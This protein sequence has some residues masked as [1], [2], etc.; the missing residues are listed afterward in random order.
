MVQVSYPGVY[1]Q[2]IPSGFR[3]ISGVA[4]SIAAFVGMAK[5]G[6]L[7][8][9][10]RVLGLKDYERIFSADTSQG[11]MTEQVRQFFIN[12]GEQAFIV[13]IAQDAQP[14]TVTLRNADGTV[15]MTLASRDAGLDAN[16]IRARVDYN[17]SSPERTF[18]LTLF[19]ETFD[20]NGAPIVSVLETHAGLGMDPDGPRFAQ[21]V[22]S[23]QS[24]LATAEVDAAAVAAAATLEA[25]SASAALF[26]DEA[27]VVTAMTNA[28]AD[29]GGTAG[30][31]RVKVGD[32]PW[33]TVEFPS[34][35]LA[36]A[37]IAT[38]INDLLAPHTTV[39]VAASVAANGPLIIRADT[40]G[41]DVLVDRA[42]QLDIA[43]ALGLGA[44][45]GGIEVGS[46]AAAR[47]APSGLV[48]VLDGAAAG[49]LAALLA[50]GGAAKADFDTPGIGGVR[51]FTVP[52]AD[53]AYPAPAPGDMNEGTTDGRSL[54]NIRENLEAIAIAM[55][56]ASDDWRAEVHGHRLAIVP[57]FGDAS[58]GAGA[59][60]TSADPDLSAANQ[61]F[62]GATAARAAES[63][64]GGDDGSVPDENEYDAAYQQIDERVDLF[65]LLILPKSAADTGD[66]TIRSR[67]WGAA[68]AFCQQQRAFLI[69]DIEP[70]AQ[71]PDGVLQ[72]LQAFRTGV[73]KDHAGVWWPQVVIASNGVRKNID[74]SGSIAGVMSRID[75]SRGVWKAP[76]GLEA[77][78]R[79]VLGV[80]VPMS[81]AQNGVLN[82]Q[83]VNAVRPFPSGVT[84]WGARTMDGFDNSGNT[85]YRYVPVRRLA[86]FIEESLLRGLKFAVFEPNDEPLWAQI[87]L[88]AGAFMNSLFRRGAFAGRTASDSYFVKADAETTTPQDQAL[89]I[90]NVLVGFAPLRPAEFIVITLQQQAGQ[91][92][93]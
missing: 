82:P 40:A 75:G 15:V 35:G 79:G 85:D 61:L 88:S 13:R 21:T 86:L 27:A 46:H 55:S 1:I 10:T 37:N 8:L 51:P 56:T 76:A 20:A 80:S 89:G 69:A 90:V 34:A 29:A 6:P 12:G 92:Q 22:V 11:E 5:R 60:F 4:T 74:P 14:A 31:F 62:D 32:A 43:Q 65:N 70:D 72:E 71:T 78:I 38:R 26:A 49:D 48:S 87:R 84:S 19:R 7:N 41:H 57:R 47:P 30:R 28:I 52:Q 83:A 39:Q 64:G 36:F 66:P 81:D 2:E 16:Q 93:V 9:P 23:Q 54:R 50:F 63:P 58:A 59:T 18:N 45:Q 3:A 24:Q 33:L 67:L 73:V 68:S 44:A 17:T 91:V 53:I 77:D 25:F 42:P